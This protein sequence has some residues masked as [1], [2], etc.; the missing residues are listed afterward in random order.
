MRRDRPRQGCRPRGGGPGT[1]LL[2]HRRAAGTLRPARRA[3]RRPA[4]GASVD[5]PERRREENVARK[6]DRPRVMGAPDSGSPTGSTSK[7]NRALVVIADG[8]AIAKPGPGVKSGR[9]GR[10]RNATPTRPRGY[11]RRRACEVDDEA[12]WRTSPRIMR[13]LRSVRSAE[14]GHLNISHESE[15]AP[16]G[17]P[18]WDSAPGQVSRRPSEATARTTRAPTRL[19]ARSTRRKRASACRCGPVGMNAL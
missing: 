7:F 13:S 3:R 17:P 1:D 12:G 11:A 4:P 9:R 6:R 18:Q 14:L 16:R 19:P 2:G 8:Q 10:C 5:T 15:G